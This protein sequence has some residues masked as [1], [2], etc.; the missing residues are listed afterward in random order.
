MTEK[1]KSGCG[2]FIWIIIIIGIIGSIFGDNDNEKENNVDYQRKEQIAVY[3]EKETQEDNNVEEEPLSFVET[4]SKNS[5]EP[6]AQSV[7]DIYTNDLGFTELEYDGKMDGTENYYIVANGYNTTA[8]AM[9]DYIR[10]F[11]PNSSYV[12]YEDGNILMT[13]EDLKDSIIDSVDMP[14]YY[15]IAQII[16]ESALKSPDSA[17][18]PWSDKISYQK[19]DN[20]VAIKGYV[21]AINSF[22]AEIRSDYIVQF[23]VYDLENLSYETTYI[24]IDGKSSGTFISFE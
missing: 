23:Y 19:K 4:M 17:D 18:F 12:F 3:E 14:Y 16:V 9:S 24:E 6:I 22:G 13:Y 2:N 21:D 15:S 10:I 5:G 1:K 8:T 20:L 7:F 11:I